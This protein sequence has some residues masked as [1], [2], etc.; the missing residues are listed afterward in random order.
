[1]TLTY[2]ELA[3][4]IETIVPSDGLKEKVGTQHCQTIS[5]RGRSGYG[6]TTLCG[7]FFKKRLSG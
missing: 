5:F 6:I 3:D 1:M 7:N 2:E 4:G